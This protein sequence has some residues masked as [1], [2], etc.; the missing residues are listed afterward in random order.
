MICGVNKGEMI[1]G[2]VEEE[3]TVDVV[4]FMEET[5]DMLW[6]WDLVCSSE[7]EPE[8]EGRPEQTERVGE[9]ERSWSS[10][11]HASEQY[12]EPSSQTFS[13]TIQ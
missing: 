6:E 11:L 12:A 7:K 1:V 2:M 8:M 13:Q 9:L 3:F 4:L 5:W 10:S